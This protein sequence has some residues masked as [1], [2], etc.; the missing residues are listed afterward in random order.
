MEAALAIGGLVALVGLTIWIAIAEAKSGAVRKEAL[1]N[2]HEVI[3]ATKRFNKARR[4]SAGLSRLERI[5]FVLREV[6]AE[7]SGTAVPAND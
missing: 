1:K 6:R 5:E 2:A 3:D 4:D 7:A